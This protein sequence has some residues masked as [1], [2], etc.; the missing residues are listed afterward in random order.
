[1]TDTGASIELTTLI[2]A[3]ARQAV[4][5]VLAAQGGVLSE[6]SGVINIA[7]EGMMLAGAFAG[8][9]FGQALGPLGG[10]AGAL[11]VGA[12][13]GGAH[14]LLTQ[15][16]RMDHIVSGVALNLLA[17]N[18]TTFLLRAFFNQASPPRPARLDHG[19]PV[20]WFVVAAVA[21][22]VLIHLGLTRTTLGLRLRA[23]GE[24]AER[25]RMAG[26]FPLRL[27][28]VGVVSSGLLAAAAGAYLSMAQVGRF[29]DDM[30]SGRG[31]IALAAVVCGRW[32]PLGAAAAAALFGL[33]DALQLL[34]QGSVRLPTEFV[35]MLPYAATILAALLLRPRPPA[36][37]GREPPA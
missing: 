18:L 30:V 4:P 5:L 12:A 3:S 24:S 27:R 25:A 33:L 35:R 36:D 15:R 7:L 1:M 19:L 13:L 14:L 29:S 21:L 10:L 16:V 6:R 2:A 20:G 34:L 23:V 26:L 8:V 32:T 11:A 22:P 17:L 37:L 9:W 31:F 28:A